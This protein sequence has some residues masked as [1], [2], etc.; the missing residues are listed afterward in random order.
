MSMPESVYL[1]AA[2]STPLAPEAL[3]VMLEALGNP[4]NPGAAHAAGHA[5][6]RIIEQARGH[7]A[8]LMR[9]GPASVVFAASATEAND[10]ALRGL[11]APAAR[12]GI[13]TTTAEHPSVLVTA[14]E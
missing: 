5:A 7:V 14:N 12:T 13:V 10:L 4:G 1:D 2:A 3:E 11:Q 6:A 8:E 9:V